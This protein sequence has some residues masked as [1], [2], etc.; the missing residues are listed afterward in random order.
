M[1]ARNYSF[2]FQEMGNFSVTFN[3]LP[4]LSRAIAWC[5]DTIDYIV[6]K[7]NVRWDC[8]RA[9]LVEERSLLCKAPQIR[10]FLFEIDEMEVLYN[11]DNAGVLRRARAAHRY[12]YV[13][14]E[15]MAQVLAK[16]ERFLEQIKLS[17]YHETVYQ[18]CTHLPVIVD[19][20]TK[21]EQQC[22]FSVAR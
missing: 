16:F 7:T 20:N 1:F 15:N 22:D 18:T 21:Q 8:V 3:N 2:Y 6:P 10:A 19:E 12:R 14:A 17:H 4:N 5:Q 13:V 9:T 11:Y